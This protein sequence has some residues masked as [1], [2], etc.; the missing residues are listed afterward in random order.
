MD[1]DTFGEGWVYTI[2]LG[3]GW[4]DTV[5]LG[6]GVGDYI[7]LRGGVTGYSQVQH[8]TVAVDWVGLTEDIGGLGTDLQTRK[9]RVETQPT[10]Q[11][12]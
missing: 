10:A 4:V 2:T 1:T 8:F 9:R 7:L 12:W 11:A 5:N 3:E 6:G